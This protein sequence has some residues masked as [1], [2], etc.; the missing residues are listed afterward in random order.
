MKIS[1]NKLDYVLA[2]QCKNLID[3][4]ESQGFSSTTLTNIRKEREVSTK[5]AGKLA[6]ALG[7]PLERLIDT[8]EA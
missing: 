1:R 3:L 5:T 8:K 2:E 4:K 7:V 6:K